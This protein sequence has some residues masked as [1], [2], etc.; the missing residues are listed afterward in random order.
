MKRNILQTVLL[1]WVCLTMTGCGIVEIQESMIGKIDGYFRA[2]VACC[3]EKEAWEEGEEKCRTVIPEHSDLYAPFVRQR[4]HSADKWEMGR[5]VRAA[6]YYCGSGTD[7]FGRLPDFL[8]RERIV[9]MEIRSIKRNGAGSV[10]W[11][12][13]WDGTD[14]REWRCRIYMRRFGE[15][16]YLIGAY[17]PKCGA[18]TVFCM[19][20]PLLSVCCY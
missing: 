4:V 2:R 16:L 6:L 10:V 1:L 15:C 11:A 5:V 13:V 19:T 14:A 8:L 17:R 20:L 9:R 7:R 3:R 18:G 12:A